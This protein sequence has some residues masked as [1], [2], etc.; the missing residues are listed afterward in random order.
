[1]TTRTKKS[2]IFN[3]IRELWFTD[4]ELK[5]LKEENGE[6]INEILEKIE[7]V[8]EIHDIQKFFNFPF[9]EQSDPMRIEID[10]FL[11]KH[12]D[13]E[14]TTLWRNFKNITLNRLPSINILTKTMIQVRTLMVNYFGPRKTGPLYE[15]KDEVWE[16]RAIRVFLRVFRWVFMSQK[17]LQHYILSGIARY[18]SFLHDFGE[19]I[20]QTS[21]NEN[22]KKFLSLSCYWLTSFFSKQGFTPEE[23][24][25]SFI[26]NVFPTRKDEK[27]VLPIERFLERILKQ[28]EIDNKYQLAQKIAS[29]DPDVPTDTIYR[30]LM[31]YKHGKES[32][33]FKTITT[34]CEKISNSEKE[35]DIL[36]FHFIVASRIQQVYLNALEPIGKERT[37][38]LFDG[39][40]EFLQDVIDNYDEWYP[41]PQK[42]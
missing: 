21:R 26:I 42:A 10:A 13:I 11:K 22:E 28:K 4:K 25:L 35:K 18:I 37:L 39:V 6:I 30:R 2:E 38:E 29:D 5:K 36:V 7:T 16:L 41:I 15:A 12:L 24:G 33:T 40:R 17:E 27:V 1:M 8:P 19:F 9:K 32:P 14:R 31:E 34:Y 3:K 20:N 23:D